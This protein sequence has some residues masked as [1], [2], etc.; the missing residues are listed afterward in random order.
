[1][2]KILLGYIKSISI[3][4]LPNFQDLIPRFMKDVRADL[5]FILYWT[6]RATSIVRHILANLIDMDRSNIKEVLI[7]TYS[8][9]GDKVTH[10]L[11]CNFSLGKRR[12]VWWNGDADFHFDLDWKI[13]QIYI[14]IFRCQ[15]QTIILDY[16]LYFIV[17][18]LLIQKRT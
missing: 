15:S 14:F 5:D 3:N 1:M 9:F 10:A 11:Y 7:E 13:S 8:D 2:F 17:Y 18:K 12:G 6:I 4:K 16:I